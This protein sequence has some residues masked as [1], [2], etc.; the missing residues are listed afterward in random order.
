[1]ESARRNV[2]RANVRDDT[3][4]VDSEDAV[5]GS[6]GGSRLRRVCCEEARTALHQIAVAYFYY[7]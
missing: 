5:R 2:W 7:R 3:F 6:V 4:A 1:L